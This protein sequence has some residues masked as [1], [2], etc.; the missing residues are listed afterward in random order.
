MTPVPRPPSDEVRAVLD[1]LPD[2][3]VL[4]GGDGRVHHVSAPAARMLGLVAAD[5]PGRPLS[6]VLRLQDQEG[7]SW[8]ASNSPFQGLAT[9]TAV[10]EQPWL[11]PD[12]SEVLVSARIHRTALSEPVDRVAITLRSG[13]GRA[14]LDRE[15]SD[16]VATVAHELRSPLTGVKGFVQALLNRW[17]KLNDDQK[18]LMLTTV[19]S[20]SDRLSRLIAELLDVARIDTGRLQLYPRPTDV[21]VVTGRVVDS[22]RAATSREIVLDA[23]DD[24]PPVQADPDKLVQVLTNLVENAVRHGEGT[25]RVT[26]ERVEAQPGAATESATAVRITVQDQGEGIPEELRRRVFTKFWKGG[27]RGG[28]GLGMYIVG[29]LTRAHGGHVAIDD[30]PGGGARVGVT[31]PVADDA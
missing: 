11:L 6:E 4:A 15:R 3:V 29:G 21:A 2:G 1:D 17:D 27:A 9:R 19:A 22:V 18:K 26:L 16:L 23:P 25:V 14:R 28:S 13:R 5:A 10:P 12:G 24:L 31:W 7:A 30:A 20:D 8:C